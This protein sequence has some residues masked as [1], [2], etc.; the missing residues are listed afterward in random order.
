M[1]R[2]GVISDVHADVHALED[3]LRHLAARECDGIV[4]CGD[5][6]DFGLFPDE[7]LALLALRKIPTISGNHDRWAVEGGGSGGGWDLS[8]ES[9]KF[10]ASLPGSHVFERDGVRVAVHHGSPRGDMDG[11]Y[12]EEIGFELA[13]QHLQRAAADVMIVGHTHIPFR[14]EV[15]GVGVIVNPAAVLRSPAEGAE[16]PP[17]TG[18]FGVLELPSRAFSVHRTTDGVEVEIL[19][20]RLAP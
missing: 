15:E 20:K 18:A 4:C 12:P 1:S 6:V 5:L 7:T 8:R 9:R 16:N 13:R 11:I 3:A 2:F 19:R 17:A 14:L 10:L